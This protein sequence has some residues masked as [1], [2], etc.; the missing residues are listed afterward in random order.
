MN[1]CDW[2]TRTSEPSSNDRREDAVMECTVTKSES[3]TRQRHD[4][5]ERYRG[6]TKTPTTDETRRGHSH[7]VRSKDMM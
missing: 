5:G 1:E 3:E 6:M 2:H 7:A 4:H